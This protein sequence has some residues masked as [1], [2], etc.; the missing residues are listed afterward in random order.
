MDG[1]G[2][3]KFVP[4]SSSSLIPGRIVGGKSGGR[5][6]SK[7]GPPSYCYFQNCHQAFVC[8]DSGLVVTASCAGL[9]IIGGALSVGSDRF[10]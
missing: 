7:K 2:A 3:V 5:P 1:G 6:V 9:V 4:L 8:G 10:F